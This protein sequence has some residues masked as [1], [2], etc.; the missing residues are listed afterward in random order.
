MSGDDVPQKKMSLIEVADKMSPVGHVWLAGLMYAAI[1][2]LL[3]LAGRWLRI[4]AGAASVIL[5]WAVVTGWRMSGLQ[6]D[7]ISE[8]GLGYVFSQYAAASL[9]LVACLASR[10]V[11]GFLRRIIGAQANQA[12]PRNGLQPTAHRS[13]R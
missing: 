6:P 3:S 4:V 5:I 9:P 2:L 7:I 10:G 8:L 13:S 1:A 11:H 12:R